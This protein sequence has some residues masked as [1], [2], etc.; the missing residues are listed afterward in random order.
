MITGIASRTNT[1]VIFINQIREKIG[2][3]FGNPETTTG[4]RSLKFYSTIRMDI[5]RIQS[6]TDGGNPVGN[7][8]RVKVVKNKV[9]PPFKVA[10]FDIIFGKG[11]S[12]SGSVLDAALEFE[13]IEASGAWFKYKGENIAQGRENAKK[14]LEENDDAMKEVKEKITE[15][16]KSRKR[17]PEVIDGKK[18]SLGDNEN[19]SDKK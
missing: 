11:I 8:T 15:Q 9:A 12:Q 13:I 2:V 18:E 3:M 7:R 16:L 17:K 1:T 5:R 14:Y 4:G 10:E 6:I 19:N